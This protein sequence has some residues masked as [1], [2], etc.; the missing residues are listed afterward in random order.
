MIIE[1][2]VWSYFYHEVSS[3]LYIMMIMQ[4][5][6]VLQYFHTKTIIRMKALSRLLQRSADQWVLFFICFFFWVLSYLIFFVWLPLLQCRRHILTFLGLFFSF[7][8]IRSF[9]VLMFS[10]WYFFSW[11]FV[12]F[13]VYFLSYMSGHILF[14]LF[15]LEVLDI[16]YSKH[17][18]CVIPA[19]MSFSFVNF[20]S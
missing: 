9:C 3:F 2:R 11:F 18:Y 4:C 1:R 13:S 17:H 19:M 5:S 12:P 14:D 20:G 16:F 15:T 7:F 10:I 8:F 6:A